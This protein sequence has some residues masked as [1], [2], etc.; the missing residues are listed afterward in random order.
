MA[1]NGK[2][3]K[4]FYKVIKKLP[5]DQYFETVRNTLSFTAPT[6]DDVKKIRSYFKGTIWKKSYNQYG[7]WWEYKTSIKGIDIRIYGVSESPKTCVA[8][9]EKRMVKERRPTEY[10]TVEVEREVI[11]GWDCGG[12]KKKN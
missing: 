2:A 4:K 3:L 7:E 8:I 1:Y 5:E 6:Q 11:V 10:E 9:K 12:K